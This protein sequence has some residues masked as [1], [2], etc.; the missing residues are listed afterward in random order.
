M[1]KSI[2]KKMDEDLR[3][4]KFF[5][6]AAILVFAFVVVFVVFYVR[7]YGRREFVFDGEV[8]QLARVQSRQVTLRSTT[9]EELVFIRSTRTSRLRQEYRY[10]GITVS[11]GG[12]YDGIMGAG[13]SMG[14]TFSDGTRA[15]LG[16]EFSETQHREAY[17][18][19]A[20]RE[21]FDNDISLKYKYPF[22]YAILLIF[23]IVFVPVLS[24][25]AFYTEEAWERSWITRLYVHGGE[26]TGFALFVLK[27]ISVIAF[28]VLAAT[29]T[30]LIVS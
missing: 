16:T 19:T 14:Y 5:I 22:Y 24:W 13:I 25:I 3:F 8:F 18:L 27:A 20:L 9:G 11:F 17:M 2:I 12:G 30:C 1:L 7:D 21:Y 6:T 15:A 29:F 28:V 10:R 26:P 4:K 23:V